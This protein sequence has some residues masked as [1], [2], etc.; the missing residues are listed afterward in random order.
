MELKNLKKYHIILASNS[1]R[2]RELLSGLGIDYEVKILPGIDESY[3]ENLTGEEIPM[4]IAREKADAYRP[5]IKPDE[6]IITADTIVCLEGQVLG[7]PKD[8]ADA[9][10]M[11]RLLSG[12]THQVITGVC[13]TTAEMQRT[14]AATT[15]VT[16]DTLSEEE[17]THYVNNYRPMDKAGAYGVQEWIGFIGV[18]RLEGSYFNVMGLPIQ[19]LYKELKRI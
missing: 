3:P 5:S 4:Y 17:I 19:R 12:R 11:L 15:D 10:R 16:F 9:C 7:K 6:L 1:P 13:I 14:F 18:T 8:E 2:R